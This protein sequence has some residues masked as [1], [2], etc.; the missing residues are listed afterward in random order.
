MRC[1]AMQMQR[2]GQRRR[3][4]LPCPALPLPCLALSQPVP[5]SSRA[6][7][8]SDGMTRAPFLELQ[9]STVCPWC[10]RCCHAM[11]ETRIR[12]HHRES[13][14]W[15][16]GRIGLGRDRIRWDGEGRRGWDEC[17]VCARARL[18]SPPIPSIC[19]Y[20]PLPCLSCP[21]L[22]CPPALRAN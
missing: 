22:P 5:L 14:R 2:R 9:R 21:A 18:Q 17:G 4:A 3:D 12:Q 10:G 11:R 15:R 19:P 6:I 1:G 13:G 20:P 8:H 16:M 7:T